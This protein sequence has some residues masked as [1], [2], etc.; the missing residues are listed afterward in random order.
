[1]M[2]FNS[3]SRPSS[4]AQASWNRPAAVQSLNRR[5][6]VEGDGYRSGKSCH[7]APET[8]TQRIPSRHRRGG[9]GG[10]PPR[11]VVRR[12]GNKSAIKNHCSSVRYGL[13]TVLDPVRFRPR[14]GNIDRVISMQTPPFACMG[15]QIAC[16]KCSVKTGF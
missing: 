11:A 5:Q 9:T 2:A 8:S 15:M 4:R 12:Y 7:R 6:Q 1:L 16:Q 3:S 13:G 10:R 14:P